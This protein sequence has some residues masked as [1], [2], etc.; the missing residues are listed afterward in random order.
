MAPPP[1][2]AAL[3][4]ELAKLGGAAAPA[5]VKRAMADVHAAFALGEDSLG[6]LGRDLKGVRVATAAEV[7]RIIKALLTVRGEQYHEARMIDNGDWLR[8]S[9]S[10]AP[11]PSQHA[12]RTRPLNAPHAPPPSPPRRRQPA[13][14]RAVRPQLPG[15]ARRERLGG[16]L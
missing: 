11:C 9:P 6:R 2:K 16:A 15:A 1:E 4:S 10:R 3:L 7:A 12:R 14:R 8:E 13:R 5:W